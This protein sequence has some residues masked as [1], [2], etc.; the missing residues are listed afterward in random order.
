MRGLTVDAGFIHD[1]LFGHTPKD[2]AR[3][4]SPSY[5]LY[6]HD[7]RSVEVDGIAVAGMER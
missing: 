4:F 2:A 6:A 3:F 7:N 5:K 1:Q